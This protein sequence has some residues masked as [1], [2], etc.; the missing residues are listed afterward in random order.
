MAELRWPLRN[1]R[2]L[3]TTGQYAL[4]NVVKKKLTVPNR[5]LRFTREMG[6]EPVWLASRAYRSL[7]NGHAHADRIVEE[8]QPGT[9]AHGEIAAVYPRQASGIREA[10]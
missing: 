9:V 6:P 7:L 3:Q 8:A 4:R 10:P 1:P 5:S 2:A